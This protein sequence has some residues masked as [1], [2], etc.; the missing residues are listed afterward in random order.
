MGVRQAAL[1]IQSHDIHAINPPGHR[2]RDRS[3]RPLPLTTADLK[4][5]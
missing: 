1:R 3:A 4:V 2:E 5:C